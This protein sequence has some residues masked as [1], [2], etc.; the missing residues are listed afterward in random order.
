MSEFLELIEF[1]EQTVVV[2]KDQP[3]YRPFPAHRAAD[4]TLTCC[5]KLGWRDRLRVL[6]NGL[7]WH[8]IMTFNQPL[9][10]QLLL[11]QKPDLSP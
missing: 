9:Q 6:W 3:Q 7:L 1:A 4:G 10:P 8:Q 2:A 5:W 11:T